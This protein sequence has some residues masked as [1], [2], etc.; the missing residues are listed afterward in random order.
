MRYLFSSTK[1]LFFFFFLVIFGV[2]AIAKVHGTR[3]FVANVYSPN[4]CYEEHIYFQNEEINSSVNLPIGSMLSI[5]LSIFNISHNDVHKLRFWTSFN[6]NYSYKQ[7]SLLVGNT[8]LNGMASPLVLHSPLASINPNEFDD[9]NISIYLGR[10]ATSNIGGTFKAMRDGGVKKIDE[11]RVEYNITFSNLTLKERKYFVEHEN[12]ELGLSYT[13]L[14]AKCEKLN[15]KIGGGILGDFNVVNKNFSTNTISND[16]NDPNNALYTQIAGQEFEVKILSLKD[17]YINNIQTKELAEFEGEIE[18]SLVRY[19]NYEICNKT[20]TSCHAKNIQKCQN[21]PLIS[22]QKRALIFN[23]EYQKSLNFTYNKA[24]TNGVFRVEYQDEFQNKKCIT[25]LDK[26]AIRPAHYAIDLNSTVLIGGRDYKVEANATSMNFNHTNKYTTPPNVTLY[27]ASHFPITC[28]AN[29]NRSKMVKFDDGKIVPLHIK[30]QNIGTYDIVL[31]DDKWTT[32]DKRKNFNGNLYSDCIV[33]S[34]ATIPNGQGK[35]GCDIWGKKSFIFQARTFRNSLSLENYNNNAFTYVADNKT[36][37]LKMGGVLTLMSEAVLDYNATQTLLGAHIAT[38][39]DKNCFAKDINLTL[40]LLDNPTHWQYET[41]ATSRVIFVS[42]NN[43][44]KIISQPRDGSV[45]ITST[46]GNFTNGLNTMQLFFNFDRNSSKAQNPFSISQKD[47][48]ITQII[49][50]SA[51]QG[52]SINQITPE[53]NVT[54]YYGRV[55][56]PNDFYRGISPLS[57]RVYYEVYCDSCDKALYNINGAESIDSI[58]WY[59]NALH[60]SR[61]LGEIPTPYETNYRSVL[62]N[63]VMQGTVVFNGNGTEDIVWANLNAPIIDTIKLY[64]NPW[65]IFDESHLRTSYN[66]YNLE[67]IK[68]GKWVGKGKLGEV[69]ELNISNRVNKRLE[70]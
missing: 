56:A 5:K 38:A 69:T 54:F 47:F 23:K 19:V 59:V 21:A 44:T 24:T 39:Y 67:F 36:E 15:R 51:V 30:T 22:T 17:K 31:L 64:P 7:D 9:K 27:I 61:D 18:I 3:A 16:P 66:E 52:D 45:K 20:D 68:G 50:S 41:N 35:V 29:E 43:T 13:G 65:L 8:N 25:S 10:G 60:V 4:I 42:D 14:I 34:N 32:V 6:K 48:N 11:A 49:D 12:S 2:N 37:P 1:K 63:S 70:W 28:L 53:T 40:K 58:N 55:H 33:D 57:T 46:D 26:F 62:G